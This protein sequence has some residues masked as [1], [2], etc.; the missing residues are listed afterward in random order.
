MTEYKKSEW[1]HGLLFAEEQ[2]KLGWK[3][4]EVNPVD[5]YINWEYKDT[6][7]VQTIFME[8]EYLDGVRDYYRNL[9][10]IGNE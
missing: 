4:V 6:T 8:N 2:H 9:R 10:E 7:G 1:Y 3:I 5:Q